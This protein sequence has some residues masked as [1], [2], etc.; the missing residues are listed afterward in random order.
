[1]DEQQ[2]VTLMSCL[3]DIDDPRKPSNGM[4]HDFQ[5]MLV[6]LISAVLSD[7]D[8]VEEI[9]SWAQARAS[10]LRR[11]L[12]LKN[13]IPSPDTLLRLL[14]LLDPKALE[15]SVRRWVSGIAPA[16]EGTIALD[17]K[18][19]RGS[20]T[21]ASLPTHMVSAFATGLGLVLGQEKVAAKSNEITAIPML[22]DALCVK[23]LL[24][25]ID[26]MGCQKDIAR[27]IIDK[28]GD[29]L[30]A[31]R[32]NQPGLHQAIID[33]FMDRSG[34]T[35]CHEHLDKN[36]GRVVVQMARVLPAKDVVD[37]ADWPSCQTIARIDSLRI[38]QGKESGLEQ[39]HYISSRA[40]SATDLAQAARAHWGIENRL[41]WVLDVSMGEDASTV[42]KDHAPRNLSLLKKIALN[43]IRANKTPMR[44]TS[45]RIKRKWADWDENLR[46]CMLGLKPL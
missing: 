16:L 34:P 15:A 3:Q 18:T 20:G 41:H 29:Y 27:K 12:V 32:G 9:G 21:G 19:L 39:R 5:E 25:S 10:W 22:L 28:G 14:R 46:M 13:G 40:L 23:G 24:V 38:S 42:R 17:G 8:S 30:L 35:A 6:V 31:V 45:L 4:L 1:M 33:A 44:K 11:F 43:L 37:P 26:A 7:C 36:H 2:G